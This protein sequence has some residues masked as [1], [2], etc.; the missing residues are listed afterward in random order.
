MKKVLALFVAVVAAVCVTASVAVA[1]PGNGVA[2]TQFT[3]TYGSFTCKGQRIVTSGT[4]A[5]VRDRET[6]DITGQLIPEGKYDVGPVTDIANFKL[7]WYSDYEYFV[8]P[9]GV[10]R[11]AVSGTI[12]VKNRPDGTSVWQVLVT[13]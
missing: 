13:Y 6:C 8:S 9:G 10:V 2:T 3:A 4:N 5:S 11:L 1:D 12:M 7:G